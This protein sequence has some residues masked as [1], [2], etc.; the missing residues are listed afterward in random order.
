MLAKAIELE[1]VQCAQEKPVPMKPVEVLIHVFWHGHHVCQSY[2]D[3]NG[4][5]YQNF[6]LDSAVV[7]WRYLR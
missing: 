6:S 4:H 5:F 7:A 2:A 1:W 3:S